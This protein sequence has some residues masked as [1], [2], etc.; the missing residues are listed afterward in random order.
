MKKRIRI[1]FFLA[2]LLFQISIA[3]PLPVGA[4]ETI[5]TTYEAFDIAL[6]PGADMSK[7][8]IAWYTTDDTPACVVEVTEKDPGQKR[9]CNWNYFAH[10]HMK[11]TG[12]NTAPADIIM[13][14]FDTSPKGYYNEA[15]ITGLKPGTEYYYR[16]GDGDGNWSA[17]Y[18][19]ATRNPREF[20][21]IYLSDAQIG[22]SQPRGATAEQLAAAIASDT[23]GW[24]NT[25]TVVSQDFPKSAFILSTGDQI[26]TPGNADQW[27]GFFTPAALT[28]IPV[29]PAIAAHD[30][31]G[32]GMGGP[33]SSYAFDYH[34]N[35]PNE[36]KHP[37]VESCAD[38][39][40][41]QPGQ[42]CSSTVESELAAGDYW[43]T[44]GKA[45]FMVL[46]MDSNDYAAHETFM[47]AAIDS[48]P[49]VKWKI[50]MFHY[51]LYTAAGRPVDAPRKAALL[52]IIQALGIDVVLTGH[53]HVYC[54]TYQML[55]DTAQTS[56]L[57]GVDGTSVINPTGV[58][59][60]V[61]NSASGSKYYDLASPMNGYVAKYY[62]PAKESRT[63][64]FSYITVN[65]TSIN[66]S[67]Y[68]YT[69]S[70]SIDEETGESITSFTP[71]IIDTYTMVKDFDD[72]ILRW[73]KP[74][75]S[76]NRFGWNKTS[77]SIPFM[78]FDSISGVYSA[79]MESPLI[80]SNE[81]AGQGKDVT[82]VD[83]GD[84]S[85]TFTSPK[86]NI[87][88]TA[89]VITITGVS[90]G[91]VF[92]VKK[93]VQVQWT[94]TDAL[95]GIDKTD[96]NIRNNGCIDTK[97]P[98]PKAITVKAIDKAGNATTKTVHYIVV[99]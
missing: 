4:D 13:G 42:P 17:T 79:S 39:P 47:Q 19:Y 26:E 58:L 55:D 23:A 71:A 44:Y 88:L 43:F 95:S 68:T 54:R 70:T 91:D 64:C 34:F 14:S 32:A 84:N 45:L 12:I 59:Y 82:V 75:P 93:K 52:P 53:D 36:T 46:N 89:P 94:A 83:Y 31:L 6:T 15:T 86:I 92:K 73:G 37:T 2:L 35:L 74:A 38:N 7:L 76:A 33:V 22:A 51:T 20:S 41:P 48:N 1:V 18:E 30:E 80:F 57:L 72:P 50:V 81:G 97:T 63:P 62:Q 21:F 85:A 24:I 66:I 90:E 98:G 87:D 25:L 40:P 28:S 9:H 60:M 56:Q 67:A 16:L 96:A 78:T 11:F 61:A 99:K 29:A 5:T 27:T 10:K 69:P 3:L 65:D 49:N 8:N 77:V